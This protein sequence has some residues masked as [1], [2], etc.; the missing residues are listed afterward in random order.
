MRSKPG[1]CSTS[2][3]QGASAREEHGELGGKGNEPWGASSEHQKGATWLATGVRNV[4]GAAERVEERDEAKG[5][6]CWVPLTYGPVT[7]PGA[8]GIVRFRDSQPGHRPDTLGT[9]T[10][11]WHEWLECDR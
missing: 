9:N 7:C 1:T 5:M 11:G 6:E 8:T 3:E 4:A 10:R 2:L